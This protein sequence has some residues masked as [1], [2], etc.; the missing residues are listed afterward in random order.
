MRLIV[1]FKIKQNGFTIIE[2]VIS[3][4]I[5]GTIVVVFNAAGSLIQDVQRANRVS[6]ATQNIDQVF[7]QLDHFIQVSRFKTIASDRQ[8][9]R[10]VLYHLNS[11]NTSS[12][13]A[14]VLQGVN[15]GHKQLLLQNSL[16]QGYAP[17]IENIDDVQFKRK[18]PYID[19]TIVLDGQAHT[20]R[21]Y[22]PYDKEKEYDT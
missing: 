7:L 15:K 17:L 1:M 10:L 6:A 2:A 9:K 20:H 3:L 13:R 11:D 16:G 14:L 19:V 12:T 4:F 18:K 21:F 8:K 22:C 5:F